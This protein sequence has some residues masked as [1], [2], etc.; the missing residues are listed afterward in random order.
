MAIHLE[1]NKDKQNKKYIKNDL[2]LHI[3]ECTTHITRNIGMGMKF[4]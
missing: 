2:K 1:D 4:I 3:V